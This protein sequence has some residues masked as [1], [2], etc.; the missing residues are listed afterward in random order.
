MPYLI[1]ETV[2][3]CLETTSFHI[4]GHTLKEA[5]LSDGIMSAYLGRSITAVSNVGGFTVV[6]SNT[7]LDEYYTTE[8]RGCHCTLMRL[9]NTA[10]ETQQ[11]TKSLTKV[12]KVA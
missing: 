6:G 3:D 5:F 4:F 8:Q 7:N 12:P 10:K 9:I 11:D 2:V 1:E